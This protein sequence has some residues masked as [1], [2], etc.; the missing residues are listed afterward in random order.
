MKN[1]S[2]LIIL[3]TVFLTSCFEKDER[4]PPYAWE[5][6][7]F[8]CPVSTY[9]N[10]VYVDL[11]TGSNFVSQSDSWDLAFES[12]PGGNRIFI[13]TGKYLGASHTGVFTLNQTSFPPGSLSFRYDKSDGDKDSTAI[14]DWVTGSDSLIYTREVYLIGVYDGV[15][16]K[17]LYKIQ[18]TELTDSAYLFSFATPA[19]SSSFTDISLTRDSLCAYTYFSFSQGIVSVEPPKTDWDLLLTQYTTTLYTDDGIPTPYFVR[20]VLLN[21]WKTV[22][23]LDTTLQFE[24]ITLADTTGLSFT[25]AR[26]V[27]GHDWKYVKV[28]EQTNTADY[29]VRPKHSYFVIDSDGGVYKIRF[30]G[31]YSKSFE[32]GYPSFDYLKLN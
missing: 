5:G 22:G 29:F 13:N 28:N 32:P 8:L 25:H 31:Y 1:F 17:P 2:F 20:G 10:Q 4:V 12:Q 9:T 11:S 23:A 19:E 3:L 18:F 6:E 7:E 15:A 14:G 30:T 21:S 26:D 24:G 16:Y 27:I